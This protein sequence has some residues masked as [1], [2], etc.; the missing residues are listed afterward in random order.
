MKCPL[1]FAR[2][3]FEGG[4][5]CIG[6]ECGFFGSVCDMDMSLSVQKCPNDEPPESD[7]V[8]ILRKYANFWSLSHETHTQCDSNWE[9]TTM[10]ALADMIERDYVSRQDFEA[11]HRTLCA[12]REQRDEWKAKA[13]QAQESYFDAKSDRDAWHARY[14]T[15]Q[16]GA[17]LKAHSKTEQNLSEQSESLSDEADSREKLEADVREWA[18]A[19][20]SELDD[21]YCEET[22]NA[23]HVAMILRW[24]DRQ[25]AITERETTLRELYKFEENHRWHISQIE[26]VR[27]LWIAK[28]NKVREENEELQARV[29]ELTAER[30]QLTNAINELQK[31]QPYCYNPEQPLDTLNTIGRY[32]DELTAELEARDKYPDGFV[33]HSEMME[34]VGELTEQLE[35]A[36]AKNRALKL[37]I[38]KMQAG[39]RGWHV[40]GVELEKENA[41]LQGRVTEMTIRL[42][43][44]RDVVDEGLA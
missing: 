29:D 18:N 9:V 19:F 43:A 39:R 34:R 42:E 3:E 16:D 23:G 21:C 44:I 4:E 7:V 28:A 1:K 20:N 38:S 8:A 10:R 27:D 5:G 41:E 40:K 12:V 13:E 26:E 36:H 37:H 33:P 11:Q 32:I 22:I 17:H 31:K 2:Y 24:L 35:A 6:A 25:A 15:L 14:V 30:D